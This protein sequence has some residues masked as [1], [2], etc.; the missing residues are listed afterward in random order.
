MLALISCNFELFVKIVRYDTSVGIEASVVA[1][2]R[3]RP[4]DV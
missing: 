4:K 3:Q 2:S 1:I